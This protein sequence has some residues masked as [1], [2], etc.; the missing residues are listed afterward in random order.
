MQE[1]DLFAVTKLDNDAFGNFWHNT[2]DSL[3][4]AYAQAFCARV[5]E[6]DSGLVGYQISTGN[7]FGA[8]LARLGVRPEAQGRGVGRALVDDLLL[9][10]TANQID[11]LSVN[12]QSDNTASLSLYQKIGFVRTGEYFPVLVHRKDTL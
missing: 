10:L 9:F 12:T 2:F 7:P 11:K 4:R 6:N 5:A 3:Q 8:H 1:A